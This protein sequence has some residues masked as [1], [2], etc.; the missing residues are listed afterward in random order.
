MTPWLL[1]LYPAMVIPMV[2]LGSSVTSGEFWNARPALWPSVA[3]N[4]PDFPSKICDAGRGGHDDVLV[5]APG[6]IGGDRPSR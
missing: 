5:P 1:E 3:T 2:P 4:A 6:E